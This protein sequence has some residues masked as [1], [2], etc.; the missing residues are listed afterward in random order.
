M[1]R[2][3]RIEVGT[4]PN[5]PTKDKGDL[6]ESLASDFLRAQGFDVINQVRLTGVELDLLCR[7]RV[8]GTEIYVEC[9]AYRDVLNASVLKTL[10]GT[11]SIKGYAEAWLISTS[12]L[13]TDARGLQ[14]EIDAKP[15]KERALQI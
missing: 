14:A 1:S 12:H 7:H 11:R 6:L 9:K 2:Q 13:G 4:R 3:A 8:R 15:A 5:A 10:E